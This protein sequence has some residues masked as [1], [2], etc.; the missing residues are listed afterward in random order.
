MPSKAQPNGRGNAEMS[1]ND[2]LSRPAAEWVQIETVTPWDKNPR[3][4][5]AAA[6][7]VA[8]SLRQSGWCDPL[9][10]AHGPWGEKLVSGH[11]RLK[12]AR[13][14]EADGTVI[15]GAPAA[16][17]VPVRR[18]H[19]EVEADAD[20][21][22]VIAN[23]SGQLAEWDADLLGEV[24]L[25]T[26]LDLTEWAWTQDDV[27]QLFE[28][29]SPAAGWTSDGSEPVRG[30]KRTMVALMVPLS[31]DEFNEVEQL[32][33]AR[34]GLRRDAFLSLVRHGGEPEPSDG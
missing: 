8:E 30:S 18:Q 28:E 20:R 13:M 16:G 12:A 14:V 25:A 15:K 22:A 1:Q 24:V 23:A 7:R 3:R 2:N 27:A 32:L 10:V 31:I 6:V 21:Y 34:G 4:N 26:K 33:T 11:T 17:L 19:F 5:D 29:E 9:V